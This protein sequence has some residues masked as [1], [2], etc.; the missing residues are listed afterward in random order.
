MFGWE[1]GV[2]LDGPLA[3]GRDI[4][5]PFVESSYPATRCTVLRPN[6]KKCQV[7]YGYMV[8]SNLLGWCHYLRDLLDDCMI[9]QIVNLVVWI[10]G[11][12]PVKRIV[13]S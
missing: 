13:T 1:V 9:Q 4:L 11:I 2:E 3:A 6:S 5:T 8:Y 10:P 7:I 12:P